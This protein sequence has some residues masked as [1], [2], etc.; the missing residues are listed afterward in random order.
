MSGKKEQADALATFH[1]QVKVIN[2]KKVA[3]TSES[4]LKRKR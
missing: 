3:R 2:L 1:V 4:D